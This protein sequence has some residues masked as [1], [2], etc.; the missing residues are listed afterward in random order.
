ML[1][2][3]DKTIVRQVATVVGAVSQAILPAMLFRRFRFD[4]PPPEVISPARWAFAAWLPIY[5][6]SL[7]YAVDQVRAG[8]RDREL[9]RE[10]GW[11]LAGAFLANG[12]W[13]PL[14]VRRRYWSAQ[15]ALVAIAGLAEVARRRL[16][17]ATARG[18]PL[19]RAE[20][21]ALAPT[22]GMLAAWSAVASGV[23][24]ASMLVGEG[25]VPKGGPAEVAGG[26]LLLGL[27][28]VGTV[29]L[30]AT[31]A[32]ATASRAY[33]ATLL[34]ALAGVVD[35]RR[36]TSPALAVVAAV[37]AIPVIRVAVRRRQGSRPTL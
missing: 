29:G 24:L 34:W 32:S 16:D 17:R 20:A 27:G 23:N 19:T 10:V 7:G 37:A 12:A 28:A 18:V 31:D 5:A 15:T 35:G 3:E 9:L 30:S 21:V 11:P 8:S 22:V 1:S 4:E 26:A 13:A 14:V 6:G 2:A 36:R 25:P 33:A